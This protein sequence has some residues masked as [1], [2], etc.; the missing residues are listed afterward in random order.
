MRRYITTDNMLMRIDA[1]VRPGRM[2]ELVTGRSFNRIGFGFSC[3]AVHDPTPLHAI[4]GSNIAH[5]ARLR[6]IQEPPSAITHKAKAL[7]M[8]HQR[9]EN[10]WESTS[11]ATLG[12]VM[13]LA[14]CEVSACQFPSMDSLL[15]R[16]S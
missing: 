14:G 15:S 7:Q 4:L 2:D 11:D 16:V 10:P 8:I 12:G 13:C 9:I 5:M 6:G 1:W 3:F